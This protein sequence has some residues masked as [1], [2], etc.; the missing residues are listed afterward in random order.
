MFILNSFYKFAQFR[1]VFCQLNMFW[2]VIEVFFSLSLFIIIIIA[3]L[4]WNFNYW[5]NRNVPGPKPRILS[6]TFPG[7][8]SRKKPIPY[9]YDEIYKKFGPKYPL[10]GV[11]SSREP[12]LFILSPK[13]AKDILVTNFK[14]FSVNTFANA[15]SS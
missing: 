9:E 1:F 12:Q 14:C 10:I 13:L 11:F 2:L 7:S 5:K 4:T 8:F 15:V 6:G 3:Y